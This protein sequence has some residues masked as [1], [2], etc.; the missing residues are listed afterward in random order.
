MKLYFDLDSRQLVHPPGQA[1]IL[2]SVSF[3]RGDVDPLELHFQSDDTDVSDVTNIVAV[4]KQAPGEVSPA[5]AVCQEW[6]EVE[7]AYVGEFNLNGEALNTLI[8]DKTSISL[9]FE[10]TCFHEGLGPI[11]SAAIKCTVKN[12]LWRDNDETPTPLPAPI[13]TTAPTEE[14]LGPPYIRVNGGKAYILSDGEW[15]QWPLQNLGD[16]WDGTILTTIPRVLYVVSSAGTAEVNG[17]YAVW[18]QDTIVREYRKFPFASEFPKITHDLDGDEAFIR[19]TGDVD[20]Y[21]A[22]SVDLLEDATWFTGGPLSGATPVPTIALAGVSPE[23]VGETVI[24]NHTDGSKTEWGA[25]SRTEWL[26]RTAGI[27]YNRTESQ[28]ERTFISAGTIQTEILP[29][30]S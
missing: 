14:T 18:Y 8:D 12:D 11:T 27:I 6:D 3:I 21:Q 5:L 30:Q 23:A 1:G 9:L 7:T 22:M 2:R 20:R 25:V 29:N 19:T 13:G 24:V 17:T 4:I 15:S 28:W 10:V 26:P 16:T